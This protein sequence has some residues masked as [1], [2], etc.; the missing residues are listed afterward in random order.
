MTNSSIAVA[1]KFIELANKDNCRLTQMQLQKL[2]YIAHGW[3]LAIY[4]SPLINTPPLAW[5]YGPV[6][7]D[8]REALRSYGSDGITKPIKTG[9]YSEGYFHENNNEVVV[10]SFTDEQKQLLDEM[11]RIYGKFEAFQLSALTHKKGT[12]WHKIY[13]EKEGRNGA[14]SDDIIKRHFLDLKER[15]SAV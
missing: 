14:I 3:S 12:P 2:A 6:Y 13:H 5:D 15:S 9:D 1:N 7:T 8:L 10:G 4:D 11:F